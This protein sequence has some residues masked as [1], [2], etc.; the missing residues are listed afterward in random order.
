MELPRH[1]PVRQLDAELARPAAQRVGLDHGGP[2]AGERS[3]TIERATRSTT[4]PPLTRVASAS[5]RFVSSSTVQFRVHG[6]P[7]T[8]H[9]MSVSLALNTTN[10]LSS[11]MRPP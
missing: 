11:R 3:T 7:G 4:S 1:V 10:R 8:V 2:A 9:R 5:G 6:P